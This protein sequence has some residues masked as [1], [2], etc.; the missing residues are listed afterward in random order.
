MKLV[1][2]FLVLFLFFPSVAF[3]ETSLSA[4]IAVPKLNEERRIDLK[5]DKS[6][7]P[8][9]IRNTSSSSQKVWTE[10]YSWGYYSLSFEVTDADGKKW[11]VRKK[12]SEWDKNIPQYW[13]LEPNDE[14]VIPVFINDAIWDGLGFLKECDEYVCKIHVRM[15]AIYEV[16]ADQESNKQ[17]V[18][19][20]KIISSENEY[21][22]YNWKKQK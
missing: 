8:I 15:K 3:A 1:K 16:N 2:L 21:V 10:W 18:W 5:D 11:E 13:T 9:V 6:S 4:S 12:P 17:N 20:G 19:A 7:F 22:F 14:L